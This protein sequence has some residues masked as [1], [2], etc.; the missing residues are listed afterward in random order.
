MLRRRF[1][2]ALG[3][4]LALSACVAPTPDLGNDVGTLN[5][6]AVAV[7]VSK[8]ERVVEGRTTTVT[9]VQLKRDLEA[10]LLASLSKYSDPNG[11]PVRVSVQV[12]KVQLTSPAAAAVAAGSSFIE[13]LV[14]LDDLST[15]QQ[16]MSPVAV[17]GSSAALRLPGVIGIVTS[18]S[19]DKDYLDTV[20]GFSETVKNALLGADT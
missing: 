20:A 17:K 8:M 19:A 15:D 7:D 12:T 18:P 5:V 16:H 2:T 11:T 14:S 6:R 3:A 13:G 4:T 10:A 1:L 9:K